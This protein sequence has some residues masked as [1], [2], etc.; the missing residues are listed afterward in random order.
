MTR[1]RQ[2]FSEDLEVRNYA[3]ST[4]HTCLRAVAA[5]A[6]RKRCLDRLSHASENSKLGFLSCSH[7][8][9]DASNAVR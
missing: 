9:N 4:I 6:G 2:K 7:A 1:L 5:F 3:R 8:G